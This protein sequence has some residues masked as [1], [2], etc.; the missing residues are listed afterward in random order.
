MKILTIILICF[1]FSLSAQVDQSDWSD[2]SELI[3]LKNI[4]TEHTE[5]SPA[6]WED[7]I[8]FVASR[9]RSKIFDSNINEAFFDLY[10]AAGKGEHDLDKTA[11]FSRNINTPAHE[12]PLCFFQN[13]KKLFY[14]GSLLD[15]D[16]VIRN[17]IYESDYAQSDWN[18]GSLNALNQEGI[19][20]C[21]PTL[22]N[23]DTLLIF[24]SDRPGGFGK[25][26]LYYS[27]Y[28]NGD[29][30][31]AINLGS[32]INSV[33]NELFPF[34]SESG[35]LFYSSDKSEKSDL[36]L[37][38]CEINGTEFSKEVRLPKPFNSKQDDFG[39]ITGSKGKKGYLSS[40]RP[41]G[42]GKDDIYFFKTDESLFLYNND[43]FN[44]LSLR[45]VD[46]NNM[47]IA[48][49]KVR[50]RELDKEESL[51]IDPSI[52]SGSD[53]TFAQSK[54]DIYGLAR[55]QLKSD[56]TLIEI[57]AE[58]KEKWVKIISDANRNSLLDIVLKNKKEAAEIVEPKIISPP[59]INNV[60][61][62]VGAVVVFNNIYY[63]YNS[64]EIKKGAAQELDQL[65]EIMKQNTSLK[66]LLSAHT[67]SRGKTD[68]NQALSEKRALAA[69]SYLIGKG[70]SPKN[71][72]TRGFGES[73]LRN[74]CKDGVNCSEAEHVYN[75][76][77]EVT[78]LER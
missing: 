74:H 4:N 52:F 47:A 68:Y 30:S 48:Q 39:L 45:I 59:K 9:P 19:S 21:H 23:S 70:I 62:K 35:F 60:E 61:L 22:G 65:A 12:G 8:V 77:T 78:V 26:D 13:S 50:Y 67:D 73:K 76:R 15:Q 64:H 31:E 43:D 18:K 38:R 24:S 42:Q 3:N 11:I 53:H 75:R 6:Y 28:T 33:N 10:Y 27:V 29:W 5:F 40:N 56:F 36:D 16:N 1:S 49:C 7:L 17:K 54:T 72:V 2:K 25:M 37:Y 20:S 71:I 32:Q 34:I 63:D 57:T 44:L 55:I 66:I 41:G 51:S 46:E 14:T 69:K 58:G